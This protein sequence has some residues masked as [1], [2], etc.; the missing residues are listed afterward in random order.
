[1]AD[2]HAN[3][4]YWLVWLYLSILTVVEIAVIFIPMARVLLVI[5]HVLARAD[6]GRAGGGLFHAPPV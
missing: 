2:A 1:M 3:P 6:Q 5:A 4:N